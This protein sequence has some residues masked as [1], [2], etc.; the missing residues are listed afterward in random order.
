MIHHF[1]CRPS[2]VQVDTHSALP[3]GFGKEKLLLTVL[4][5]AVRYSEIIPAEILGGKRV[6]GVAKVF[7]RHNPF[8]FTIY[9]HLRCVCIT[10]YSIL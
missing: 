5:K 6:C 4:I 8:M 2:S 7:Y 1:M 9:R 10:S 3:V